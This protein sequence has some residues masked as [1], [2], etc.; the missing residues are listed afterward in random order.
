MDISEVLA[1]AME[2]AGYSEAGRRIG[3]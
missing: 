3:F 2:E 1:M